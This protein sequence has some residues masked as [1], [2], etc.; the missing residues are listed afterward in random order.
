MAAGSRDSISRI[1]AFVSVGL[2]AIALL[3]ACV[4]VGTP[5]WQT[6]YS[7]TGG[8]TQVTSYNN[9]FYGCTGLGSNM[10]C[11]NRNASFTGYGLSGF[12]FSSTFSAANDTSARFQSAAGLSIVG[13]I[14]IAAGTIATLVMAL[15]ALY[16]WFNLIPPALLFLA[17]LFMLAALAEGSR[18]LLY[19][20]YA[21]NLYQTAH[22]LTIL[23][24]GLSALAAGR[25]HF[26]RMYTDKV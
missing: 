9:F 23:S 4:G 17:C 21:A 24:F 11:Y 16:T 8:S 20:D 3:L 1:L 5:G 10:T 12:Y 6:T 18:V 15:L 26:E 2:G 7:T 19:N 13:I 25:F 22:L 14:F